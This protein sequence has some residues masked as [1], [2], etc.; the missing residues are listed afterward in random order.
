MAGVDYRVSV[1]VD[2]KDTNLN[3]LQNRLNKI[4]GQNKAIKLNIDTADAHKKITQLETR[5]KKLGVAGTGS[6]SA[7]SGITS[8][9]QNASN[10]ATNLGAKVDSIKAKFAGF[11]YNNQMS[12]LITSFNKLGTQSDKARESVAQLRVAY[13]QLRTAMRSGDMNAI[14]AADQNFNAVLTQGQNIMRMAAR[15][16]NALAAA[17]R[18]QA[19]AA[20]TAAQQQAAA[21]RAAAQATQFAYDKQMLLLR[22]QKYAKEN[23]RISNTVYGNALSALQ[24]Q[25]ASTKTR[26]ALTDLNRQF[27]V[28]GMNV[29]IAGQ[30]GLNFTDR[31]I[32]QF[33]RLG[34]YFG[35]STAIMM[36]MRAIKDMYNNV[37]EVDTAMTEL[38]RVTDLSS[39]QY[40]DIYNGLT[41]SA[42]EYGTTLKDIINATADWSRAGF[43]AN[44]ATGLAEVTTMYQHIADVDYQT[45]FENLE[46]AYKGFEDQ[47]T[48]DFGGDTV[49]AISYIGDIYNEIDNNFAA[50]A[51]DVGEAI[52]RSASA[53]NIAGNTIQETV[54]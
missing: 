41:E 19:Q 2:V 52:K 10:A 43:D 1:V 47:L 46:T 34:S 23:S 37:L 24:Q 39:N 16:A 31:L 48:K 6:S 36:G 51:D 18:A 35:A 7:I 12:G 8:Q 20:R 5:L 53:L 33:R 15:E 44:I 42:R 21:Q 13:Q 28:L 17:Q 54:G 14:I 49:A 9:M 29:S 45:A 27:Q 50:T 22:M 11:G 4:S 25:V 30:T 32:M 40:T 3:D 38:Y 26:S